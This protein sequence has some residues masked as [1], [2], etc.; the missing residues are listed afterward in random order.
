[1]QE[2]VAQIM[3]TFLGVEDHGFFTGVV[4]LK[5]DNTTGQGAGNYDLRRGQAACRFVT[6]IC[7]V[8]CCPS[9]EALKGCYVVALIE[10]GVVRGFRPLPPHGDKAFMFQSI[11]EED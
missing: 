6:G 8:A 2:R 11:Y 5:Y 9:W 3:S 7:R 1:M 10:D 4:D